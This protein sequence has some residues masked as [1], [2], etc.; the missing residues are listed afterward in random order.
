LLDL[1]VGHFPRIED[2]GVALRGKVGAAMLVA[3][4]AQRAEQNL[5]GREPLLAVDDEAALNVGC[6]NLL[7]VEHHRAEEVCW[8]VLAAVQILDEL[9]GN[10]FPEGFPV[11][12]LGPDVLSLEQRDL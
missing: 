2:E 7:L 6:G 8:S 1:G 3:K 12:V 4:I 11:L 10:V 5:E 9:A